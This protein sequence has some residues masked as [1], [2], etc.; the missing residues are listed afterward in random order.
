MKYLIFLFLFTIL[1]SGVFCNN[2]NN[3]FLEFLNQR[4]EF[5]ISECNYG[6][7][8]DEAYYFCS[9]RKQEAEEIREEFLKLIEKN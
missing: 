2:I 3:E 8:R 6:A 9:G 5:L 1:N 7:W 4:I